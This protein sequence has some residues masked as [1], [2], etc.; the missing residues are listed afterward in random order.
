MLNQNSTT[1]EICLCTEVSA[2]LDGELSV[3]DEQS[4]E[5][6]LSNCQVCKTELL[7]QK[8]M[9]CALNFAFDSTDRDFELPKNFTK[10]IVTKAE[11][12]VSGLRKP[13]E[14]SRAFVL[15]LILFAFV[16]AALGESLGKFV[17][18]WQSVTEQVVAVVSVA[19]DFSVDIF[20]GFAVI[21]RALNQ[22]FIFD[23]QLTTWTFLIFFLIIFTLFSRILIRHHRS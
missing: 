18:I 22:T 3:R 11:S 10:T 19:V 12:N 13:E 8:Q 9:L 4:F 20:M 21:L 15:C 2:Y 5:H 23:S 1:K 14:R 17:S 6:H 16:V 7:S